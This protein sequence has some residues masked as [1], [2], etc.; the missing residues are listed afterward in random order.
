M[1]L[2][3]TTLAA[4]AYLLTGEEKY[5]TWLLEYV[6]AWVARTQENQG[7]I[8]SNIGT[9]GRIGGSHGGRWY[10]GAYGWAF[11]FKNSVTGAESP[12]Q[13][14]RTRPD[15]IRERLPAHRGPPLHRRL[16]LDDGPDQLPPGRHVRSARGSTGGH[17]GGFSQDVRGPGMV[18]LHAQSHGRR[19]PWNAIS[20]PARPGIES[21]FPPTNGYAISKGNLPSTR[22]AHCEPTFGISAARFPPCER[23]VPH[24]ARDCPT[25]RRSTTPYPSPRCASRC[26]PVSTPAGAAPFCTAA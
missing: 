10:G 4:N 24:R 23:T 15:R 2:G 19:E 9:D 17:R 26:W 11:T 5:K 8:P 21:G 1:N 3:A 14:C 22:N 13:S 6:D 18:R 7:I 25:V 12:L 16:D 20:G